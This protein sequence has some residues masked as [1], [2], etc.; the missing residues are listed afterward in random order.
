MRMKHE[1]NVSS[2][3]TGDIPMDKPVE[4]RAVCVKLAIEAITPA[5]GL[6]DLSTAEVTDDILA[7]ARDFDNY[8]TGGA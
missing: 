1:V 3:I 8:I 2:G 7:M 4:R 6:H 5:M